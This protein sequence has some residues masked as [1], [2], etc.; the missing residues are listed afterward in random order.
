MKVLIDTY[1]ILLFG[2]I[3]KLLFYSRLYSSKTETKRKPSGEERENCGIYIKANKNPIFIKFLP[4]VY[5]ISMIFR[6]QKRS[7]LK[8]KKNPSFIKWYIILMICLR[9]FLLSIS[10]I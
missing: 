5:L 4:S 1:I 10:F 3:V 9:S 2:F 6:M 7:R 8:K